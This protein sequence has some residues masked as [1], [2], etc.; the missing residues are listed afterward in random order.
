MN[1]LLVIMFWV[2]MYSLGCYIFHAAKA[3]VKNN[4]P[5]R[6]SP[7]GSGKCDVKLTIHGEKVP[8]D[9]CIAD[10]VIALNNGGIPTRASCCG[11]GDR[12]WPGF[13]WLEDG[14]HFWLSTPQDKE[15]A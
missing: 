3:M 6:C 14:R 9:K 8:V 13:I 4:F 5:K 11:H 10:I 7:M 12:K 15:E 1:D 2:F